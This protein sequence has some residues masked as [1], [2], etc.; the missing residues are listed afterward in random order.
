VPAAAP[1]AVGLVAGVGVRDD[2]VAAVGVPTA[3]GVL[4][5]AEMS[6]ATGVALGRGR[7]VGRA[8]RSGV[9][10]TVGGSGVGFGVEGIV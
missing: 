8:I 4:V 10:V 2:L 1:I 7:P 6:V 3:T 9:L 5:M